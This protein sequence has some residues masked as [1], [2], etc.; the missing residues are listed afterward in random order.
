MDQNLLRADLL[1]ATV[2]VAALWAMAVAGLLIWVGAHRL[3]VRRSWPARLRLAV[4]VPLGTVASWAMIQLLGRIVFLATPW[5]V[6]FVSVMAGTAIEVVSALY[7]RECRLLSRRSGRVLPVLRLSAIVVV[8]FL[9]L[10]PVFVGEQT[11]TIR[12]RVVVLVDDSASMHLTDTYWTLPEQA[13]LAVALGALAVGKDHLQGMQA[14]LE[15]FQLEFGVFRQWA[16][17]GGEGVNRAAC[18]AFAAR[19][20]RWFEARSAVM[21]ALVGAIPDAVRH[22]E[23]ETL[24]ALATHVKKGVLPAL[25]RLE[26]ACDDDGA[27]L[28]APLTAAAEAVDAV[29]QSAG[30]LEQAAYLVALER[31]ADA[32]RAAVLGVAQ[33]N[34]ASLAAQLLTGGR[35][36]VSPMER[37]QAKYD[38]DLYRFGAQAVPTGL[39]AIQSGSDA[40]GTRTDETA[41]QR[42]RAREEA[43]RS[44][45]DLTA[46]METVIRDVPF[47]ELAGLLFLTDG[48]HTGAASVDAVSRRLGNARVPVCSVIIGGTQAPMDLSFADVRAPDSVFLGDR[49][50]ISGTLMA[51]G[52]AG[53]RAT[54][55]LYYEEESVAE[56][57]IPIG[58]DDFLQEFRFAHEPEDKGVLHYRLAIDT[59]PNEAFTNNNEW[60]VDVSVT[61]D[62]TNVL[63]VDSRPRWEFRYLRNLFYGRDKS[64]HLQEYL[65]NP[66]R[67]D[68]IRARPLPPASAAR[69]FG[70]SESGG[71][72][73]S[74]DEWR[75]FDVIIIGDV[76]FDELPPRHVEEIRYCVEQRG[77]LL[78]VIAGPE[79]MPHKLNN[80]TLMH[81]LPIVYRTSGRDYRNPP[82]ALYHLRLTPA[83]RGHPIMRQSASSSENEQIWQHIPP[84]RWRF[85]VEGVKPGAEVLAYAEPAGSDDVSLAQLAVRDLEA[86]PDAAVRRLE[87]LRQAQ[88]NNALIVGWNFGQ[89]KVMML[90]TDRTWRLRYQVGDTYHHQFW[91]QVLR[92]GT[93]E[94][95]RSGNAFVRVG[96]D[97]LRY[98]PTDPIR[99][100]ARIVDQHFNTISR[101]SPSVVFT[102]A[103][104]RTQTLPLVYRP[105]S[106]GFYEA[107]LDPIADPGVYDLALLAPQ[108]ARLL[109]PDFPDP[110]E[111][112]FLVVTAEQP[113]E[114]ARVTASRTAPRQMALL[115]GGRVVGPTGMDGVIDAFG[116]GNRVLRERTERNLW[117][118]WL[119]FAGVIGLLGAEW[120]IR[121]RS[122]VA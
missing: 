55:R 6:L 84:M 76:H 109:G 67:V 26:A 108:A 31:L 75:Q 87:A 4:L 7:R 61:D 28:P 77:A 20:R 103:S 116:E 69:R 101:L 53:E 68:G 25:A 92:W 29:T 79:A 15:A 119:V 59:L 111:T 70:D 49:V 114:F 47:E 50:R 113:A 30:V 3:I 74:R 91:G 94:K 63:L 2:S 71:Y 86:D 46:A 93:G 27:D 42:A 10:Q 66:D 112:R 33:T 41:I 9:L 36:G 81:M 90:N 73:V 23:T 78:I 18:A 64:V 82:E 16:S 62:R 32:D 117:D 105:D 40:G 37:L 85:P 5:H 45:T 58:S 115:S 96:T 44:S 120:I 1:P 118:S 95:L 60:A 43:F 8:L 107:E 17:V 99:V 11:R 102:T 12:R 57:V 72:P 14:E 48:R 122:G 100:Y 89:G 88:E 35:G 51:T 65:V 98:A 56:Q 19:V 80:D 97:K 106:N 21:E 34:R 121:K 38:V 22:P 52:A 39:A 110:L 54:I 83:G 13:E 104:G 24:K